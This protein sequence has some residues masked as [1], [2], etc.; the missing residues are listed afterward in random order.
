M[1]IEIVWL[2]SAVPTALEPDF[3]NGQWEGTQIDHLNCSPERLTIESL[4]MKRCDANADA[5]LV[6]CAP[7]VH[8]TERRA[9]KSNAEREGVS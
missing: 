5:L 2:D 7:G 4:E 6:Y 1:F 8:Y 9:Q 3:F